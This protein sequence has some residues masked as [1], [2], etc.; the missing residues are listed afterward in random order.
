MRDAMVSDTPQGDRTIQKGTWKG[1]PIRYR[2]NRIIVKFNP[3]VQNADTSLDQLIET[4]A[5]IIPGGQL[6]RLSQKSGRAIFGVASTVDIIELANVLSA[7]DDVDYA[8]PDLVD[9]TA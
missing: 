7:R 4:I 9:S 8:E 5:A 1:R 2:S 6:I 3:A